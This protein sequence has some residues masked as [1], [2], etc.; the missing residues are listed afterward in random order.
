QDGMPYYVMQFIQGLG[1]DDVLEELKKLQVGG[2]RAGTSMSG[3]LRVSRHGGRVS[4]VPGEGGNWKTQT[5]GPV[6]ALNVARSLLT[7]EFQSPIDQDDEA[8]TPVTVED[9]RAED[10]GPSAPRSPGLS[11]SFTPTSSSVILPGQSRDGSKAR[12]RKR[13]YWQSVASIGVQ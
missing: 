9:A 10:P 13:S 2:A 6:S 3:E 11:D 1:L 12:N 7:G 8:T 4:D 5:Q